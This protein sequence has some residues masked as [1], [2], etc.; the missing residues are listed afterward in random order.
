MTLGQGESI[1]NKRM[2]SSKRQTQEFNGNFQSW[3]SQAKMG[4]FE[5]PSPWTILKLSPS[6]ESVVWSS[7]EVLSA[8]SEN[9]RLPISKKEASIQSLCPHSVR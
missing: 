7:W 2:S 9:G 5:A 8:Q 1:Q 3:A 4:G 6:L